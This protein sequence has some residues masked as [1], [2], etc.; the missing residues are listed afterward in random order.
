MKRSVRL[1]SAATIVA[2]A[3]ALVAAC[4][5][6]SNPVSAGSSTPASAGTSSSGSGSTTVTIGSANFTENEILMD[7]YAA[8]LRAKGVTVKTQ[9][10]IGS[11]EIYLPLIESGKLTIIPEYNGALLSNFDKTTTA[12]TKEATDAE[13]KTKL[14]SQLSLLNDS[15]AE[16]KDSLN[17]TQANATKYGL[18]TIADLSKTPA[19]FKLGAPP[20]F[21]T[22]LQGLLGLKSV[23]GLDLAS[24]FVPLDEA[25]ARTIA[26]LKGGN[27][28]VADIFSTDAS[29][30]ANHFVTLSD[31][32]GLFGAQNV[33][34]LVYTAGVNST[35]TDALNAFSAKLTTADLLS[36]VGKVTNDHDD[37]TSVAHDYVKSIGLS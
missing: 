7:A 14:P 23:Y 32:K 21:S 8:V 30:A 5:S 25:G 28:G 3:S 16:D 17:V 12:T 26:A 4:G 18:S 31:P 27:V 15:A 33:V 22:R 9:P 36:M 20:E 10:E 13:L 19:S 29:I 2:L 1:L 24:R 11:R 6:S 35:I 34:P 37:A